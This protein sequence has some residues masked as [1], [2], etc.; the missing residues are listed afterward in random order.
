MKPDFMVGSFQIPHAISLGFKNNEVKHSALQ[1]ILRNVNAEKHQIF[2]KVYS[3]WP[4]VM[5][6]FHQRNT[7]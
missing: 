4:V 1:G 3:Y 5:K 7:T 6:L 2:D